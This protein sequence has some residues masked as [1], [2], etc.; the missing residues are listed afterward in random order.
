MPL[1]RIALKIKE[2]RYR[3]KRSRNKE[4]GEENK[5]VRK[6]KQDYSKTILYC[7]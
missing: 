4:K 1:L 3:S 5:P 6:I 2:Y 7:K